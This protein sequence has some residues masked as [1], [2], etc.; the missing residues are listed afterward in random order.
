MSAVQLYHCQCVH[1][2]LK[3]LYA[4][5]MIAS[6]PAFMAWRGEEPAER[7]PGFSHFHMREIFLEIWETVLFW[8]YIMRKTRADENS[9]SPLLQVAITWKY[10]Q[11]MTGSHGEMT[12]W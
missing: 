7:T 6:H 10:T 9:P 2:S 1:L 4:V 5:L 3:L 11:M 8:L 12:M